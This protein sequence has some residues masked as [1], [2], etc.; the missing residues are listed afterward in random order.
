LLS[1]TIYIKRGWGWVEQ[2][3]SATLEILMKQRKSNQEKYVP[4]NFIFLYSFSFSKFL[5]QK[6]MHNNNLSCLL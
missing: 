1:A 5:K 6:K 2:I 4:W 3:M